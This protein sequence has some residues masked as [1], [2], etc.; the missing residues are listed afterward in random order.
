[1]NK[2]PYFARRYSSPK[3][4]VNFIFNFDSPRFLEYIPTRVIEIRNLQINIYIEK[5]LD[6]D[7][8]NSQSGNNFRPKSL[9]DVTNIIFTRQFGK[10]IKRPTS[11]LDGKRIFETK[12]IR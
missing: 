9:L 7:Y 2:F 11:S 4:H 3:H 10:K 5:M 1:M 8:Y 12:S 6:T